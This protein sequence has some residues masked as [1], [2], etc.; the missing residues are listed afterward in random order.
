[1]PMR[2]ALLRIAILSALLTGAC[3][4]LPRGFVTPQ[5]PGLVGCYSLSVGA[6]KRPDGTVEQNQPEVPS[7]IWLT[8]DELAMSENRERAYVLRVKPGTEETFFD[9]AKWYADSNSMIHLRWTS[10]MVGLRAE[11]KARNRERGT[12][13]E[14]LLFYWSD[15]LAGAVLRASVELKQ[16]ACLGLP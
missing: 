7:G 1:M 8:G 14:G 16:E 6:W 15:D 3:S 9:A 4:A 13:L 10:P 11:L 2:A 5:H 12:Q